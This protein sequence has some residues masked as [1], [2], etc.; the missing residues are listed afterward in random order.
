V[1]KLNVRNMTR[2]AKGT[3]EEPGINVRQKAGLNR[4]M[5][6]ASSA[7]L[8]D[9]I[10]YKAER[11]GGELVKVD[12]RNTSQD[13]SAC[14]ARVPKELKQRVHRC[15]CGAVLQRDHNAATNVLER[16]LSAH[17]RA[18]PPGDANAGHRPVRRLGNAAAVA[19]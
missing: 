4:S 8:V 7:R 15:A 2:S 5:L 3:A 18:R 12:A 17:G 14:G 9:F 16:A 19:A 13:C 1:E 10:S 6:D 11:A